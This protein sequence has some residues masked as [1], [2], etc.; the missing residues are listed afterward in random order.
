MKNDRRHSPNWLHRRAFLGRSAGG[1]GSLALG[2]LLD[3]ALLRADDAAKTGAASH[4]PGRWRGAV[5]PLHFPASEANH[6]PLH[7]RR[8]VAP[9]NPGL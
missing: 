6:L 2:A 9:G 7:G 3:P 4:S 5:S 1:I 8:S